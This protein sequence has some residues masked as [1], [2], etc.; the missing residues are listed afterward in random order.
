MS[1][2]TKLPIRMSVEEFLNW[3]A[4]DGL[5]WQLV[6]GEPRCMAPANRTHGSIQ[7]RLG[8]LLDAHLEARG[9]ACTL[10]VTPGVV[11]RMMS[12]HNMR[13]PDLAVTCSSYEIE[14]SA[15]NNPVL[16]IQILSLS[17]QTE[18]WAN[19]W[20]YTT[21]PSV[22]EILIVRTDV[23]GCELLRR[24]LDGSWPSAP[25]EI[26]DGDLVLESV[27][28]RVP[29]ADVYRTTRLARR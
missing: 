14:E 4:G 27:E 22:T 2:A 19:V 17:N 11:P 3:D 23:I 1:A 16:I 29:L 25:E 12:K 26:T 21:I 9:G 18:T 24:R 20:T 10:V 6:D 5:R 15:L 7:A 8:R 28:F 13:V